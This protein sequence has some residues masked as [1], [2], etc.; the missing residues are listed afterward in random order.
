MVQ[1]K[2]IERDAGDDQQ[3]K[4]EDQAILMDQISCT[5]RTEDSQ[6]CSNKVSDVLCQL[7]KQHLVPDV[8]MNIYVVNP[9]KFKYFRT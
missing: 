1:P 5:L 8:D 4:N 2:A 3:I 7:V 9:L 6:K